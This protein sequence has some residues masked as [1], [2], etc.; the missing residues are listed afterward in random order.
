MTFFLISFLILAGIWGVFIEP[1]HIKVEKLSLEIKDLPTSFKN[2]KIL[3]LSDFHFKK[4]G[5]KEKKVLKILN[6]LNPDFIFITGDIIDVSTKNFESCYKFL[7]ELSKNYEAKIFAVYGN[8]DHQN[9]NFNLFNDF[10]AKSR[11]QVLNNQA[12]RIDK[13]GDF[14]YL[15]GLDDPHLEYDDIERAMKE[16]E[17]NTS[18]ILIA[19][20]PEIFRKIR[21]K[22]IDLVLVGH[23][24]GGQINIPPLPYF[25][26]PLKHDKK[27]KSGL[28]KEDSTY[29]YINLGIGETLLPI[30]INAMPEA[31]LIEL[32]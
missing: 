8:H 11:I 2:S 29:L 5:R 12:Q 27:Y 4:F 10:L 15:I 26:L 14:I 21:E 19:H 23:T 13:D 30:R 16:I 24:H 6:R 9:K 17:S 18:K 20:S 31:T 32:K 28:F 7:E 25:T 22:D 1:N 3:H